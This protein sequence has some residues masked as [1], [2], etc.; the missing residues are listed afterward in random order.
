M[1]LFRKMSVVLVVAFV[2]D[3]YLRILTLAWL[4]S[5][6]YVIQRF[7]LWILLR[8][9][10]GDFRVLTARPGPCMRHPP[11]PPPPPPPPEF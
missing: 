10:G 1:L 9:G 11:A 3:T 2:S 5:G 6:Y 8:T 4:M 7:L